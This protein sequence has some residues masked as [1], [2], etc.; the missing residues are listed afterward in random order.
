MVKP[1][2]VFGIGLNKTGTSS[3]KLALQALGYRHHSRRGKVT[4]AY[5]KGNRDVI[6]K[7]SDDFE[8]FEDWPWPLLYRELFERYGDSA[9][10]ILTVRK[11]P[12]VWLDSLKGHSEKTNPQNNPREGIYGFA[13]PHGAEAEHIAF[14]EKHNR[15]VREFFASNNAEHQLV[16]LCWENGDG[17]PELCAHLSEPDPKTEF[18]HANNNRSSS[19]DIDVLEENRRLINN[20]L[21]ELKK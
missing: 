13:Y 20:Q 7:A 5:F 14:Y 17:W 21:D 2:K 19:A 1:H 6:F 3:L 15:N 9:R 18:P 12:Q 16:E 4:S 11:S 10:Y 8:S